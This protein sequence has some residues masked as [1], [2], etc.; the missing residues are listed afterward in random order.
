MRRL[1]FCHSEPAA[2]GEVLSARNNFAEEAVRNRQGSLGNSAQ[3]AADLAQVEQIFT[4]ADGAGINGALGNLFGS[5][6]QLTVSPNDSTSR[7]IVLD[8][9]QALAGAINSAST[10]LS[11]SSSSLDTQAKS[12]VDDINRLAAQIADLNK[13]LQGDA[14][15][16][17][18]A[19]LDAQ[20]NNNLE[21]L[22]KIANYTAIHQPDGSVSVY[23][24]GQTP[25]VVGDKQYRIGAGFSNGG[26]QINDA[27]GADITNQIA[28]GQLSGLLEEKNS[29]FPLYANDL[30]TLAKSIAERV[31]TVLKGGLDQTG[32][33]PTTD[34]FAYDSV[35]GAAATL[36]INKLT[37][38][39]L[40]AALPG[41]AG[42]NGN[43]LNLASLSSSKEIGG[44]SFS[45]Y[46]GNIASK[47]GRDL[48][49]AQ[50]GQKVQRQLLDQSA[51]IRE[52]VS[53]V[54]L[55]EEAA[56]LVELQRKYQAAAKMLSVLSDMTDTVVGLIK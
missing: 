9:A 15:T 44:Y 41:A 8:R 50:G 54:N 40:A 22:S 5:F 23:L 28:R 12:A 38:D 34:L 42:G 30:N 3:K 52:Q 53:G 27:N 51:A 24:G 17:R 32:A 47:V 10:D 2:A 16:S 37:P 49:D 26:I 35:E 48:S 31:N 7:Q 43:A 1:L 36:K 6:S 46:Y 45:E 56:H 33:A 39:Q 13:V 55:D 11:K 25:I 18:D 19:G 14:T 20:L 29:I 21:E 4:I